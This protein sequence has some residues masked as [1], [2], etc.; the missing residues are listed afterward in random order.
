M[1]ICETIISNVTITDLNAPYN[2]TIKVLIDS[3]LQPTTRLLRTFKNDCESACWDAS[4]DQDGRTYRSADPAENFTLPKQKRMPSKTTV[5][6]KIECVCCQGQTFVTNNAGKKKLSDH[7]CFTT[8]RFFFMS[9][10]TKLE[11]K[12]TSENTF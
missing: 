1:T 6:G 8:L 12:D 10:D 2:T 7:G 4:C 9:V 5:D 3:L 11:T